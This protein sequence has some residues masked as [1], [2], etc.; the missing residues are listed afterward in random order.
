MDWMLGWSPP[1]PPHLKETF[2]ETLAREVNQ[3]T[4]SCTNKRRIWHCGGINRIGLGWI[5]EYSEVFLRSQQAGRPLHT[6][7]YVWCA[8]KVSKGWTGSPTYPRIPVL[9]WW[10]LC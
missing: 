4:Q 2:E 6:T 10:Q 9:V 1:E 7:V 3:V 5:S 8:F